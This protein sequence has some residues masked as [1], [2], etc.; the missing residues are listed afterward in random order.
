MIPRKLKRC[1]GCEK[2]RYI[3]SHGNCLDCHNR[4]KM[5]KKPKETKPRIP[6]KPVSDKRGKLDRAYS[7]MAQQFKNTHPDCMAQLPGCSHV[8]HHVHHLYS[9]ASRSKYYLDS[10]TWIT[11]CNHCHHMIHDVMGK[12][13]LVKLGLKK[14]E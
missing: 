5:A 7:T 8:T 12:D 2:D 3:F 10:T 6:I 1:K 4:L 11:C 14:I 13:E 9:G